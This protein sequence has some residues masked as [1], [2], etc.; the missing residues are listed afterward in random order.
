M[1]SH[2]AIFSSVL[3]FKKGKKER[4]RVR[5]EFMDAHR[6]Q[7]TLSAGYGHRLY[8]PPVELVFFRDPEP[9]VHIHEPSHHLRHLGLALAHAVDGRSAHAQ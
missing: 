7:C 1:K 8:L 5:L 9:L 2:W 6:R 4:I 3:N